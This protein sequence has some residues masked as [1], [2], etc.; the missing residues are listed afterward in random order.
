M[1]RY[2]KEMNRVSKVIDD[3]LADKEW[4]V[5]GKCSY[6][7]L[8]WVPWQGTV[9]KIITKEDGYDVSVYP[10]MEA[11]LNRMFGRET[12]RRVMVE[13]VAL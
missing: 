9:G 7:D 4:L 11:W 13:A 8:A 1:E 3:F 6:A 5:G 2:V 10:N 12:V